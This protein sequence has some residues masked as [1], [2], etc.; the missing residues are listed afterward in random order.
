MALSAASKRRQRKGRERGREQPLGRGQPKQRHALT[1]ARDA[2]KARRLASVCGLTLECRRPV[3]EGRIL[4]YWV[5]CAGERVVLLCWPPADGLPWHWHD[6]HGRT[7]GQ[8]R[9]LE[10][11]VALAEFLKL[12]HEREG[13]RQ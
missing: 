11:L 13:E 10:S 1:A 7:S 2:R 4:P 6:T 8:A 3:S 12:Q 9:S 5:F